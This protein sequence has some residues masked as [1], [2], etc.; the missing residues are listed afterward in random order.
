MPDAP[1][2]KPDGAPKDHPTEVCIAR[3][4]TNRH[5]PPRPSDQTGY[6]SNS[7]IL[8]NPQQNHCLGPLGHFY[9]V[10]QY[11]IPASY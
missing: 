4:R 9:A 10:L 11:V 8:D 5:C 2:A 3:V 6:S 7:H 1:Q